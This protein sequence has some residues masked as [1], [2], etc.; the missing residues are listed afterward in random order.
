MTKVVEISLHHSAVYNGNYSAYA[1]K[2]A[3]VREERLKAYENQQREIRHQEEVIEKLKSFNREKSIRR[4]ESREKQLA[5]IEVMEK[6]EEERSRMNITLTPQ[7]VSGNDVLSV[8][9]L[10]KAFGS[11]VLFTDLS[12]E[13]K[14]GERVALIGPNGTGKTTVLKILNQVLDADGGSFRLGT[15]VH[16]GYYDQEQQVLHME[17]NLMEEISDDYPELTNTKIRN[18][19]AGVPFYGG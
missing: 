12:F 1:E 6:P 2:A 9:H 10:S 16:I 15:N 11:Q 14:R 4:A 13:I 7:V 17:K 3:K 8:E 18:V 19:L 5:K